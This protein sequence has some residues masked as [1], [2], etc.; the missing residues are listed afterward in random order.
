MASLKQVM[1]P[2][3]INLGALECLSSAVVTSLNMTGRDYRYFIA[4]YWNLNCEL[5]MLL[6]SRNFSFYNLE[7]IYGMKSDFVVGPYELLI[8]EV[9][10]GNIVIYKVE[11]SKLGFF[12]ES[13]LGF[14]NQFFGHCLLVYKY[15]PGTQTFHIVDPVI[16][17]VGKIS[18]D[19]LIHAS[20][21]P[22]CAG[23]NTIHLNKESTLSSE[24]R[25]NFSAERN[26]NSY[27]LE[28]VPG[29]ARALRKFREIIEESVEW[30]Q[31][32]RNEWSSKNSISIT[33]ILKLRGLVWGS[34][35]SLAGFTQ[36]VIEHG[37]KSIEDISKL[38]NSLNLNILKI[39]RQPKPEYVD[40]I[41]NYTKLLEEKEL[42]FLKF[43][44]HNTQLKLKE[45]E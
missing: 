21:F 10:R 43:V 26:Y 1:N 13:M 31:E 20:A 36:D 6:S 22:S 25:L 27:C 8:R 16:K 7:A 35:R 45:T 17:Y 37:D 12:P 11:A 32:V 33:S 41:I 34:F 18:M 28:Y 30:T 14:E 39:G 38:W 42:D 40:K 24:Q 4:D 9:E 23:M 2:E 19:E 5:K 44:Y 15:E 29:G 3:V